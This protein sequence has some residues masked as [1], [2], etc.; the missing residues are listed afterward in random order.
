MNQASVVVLSGKGTVRVMTPPV[1]PAES[2]VVRPMVA[3]VSG[4]GGGIGRA[5]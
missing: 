3:I 5:I 2:E 4:G 1:E